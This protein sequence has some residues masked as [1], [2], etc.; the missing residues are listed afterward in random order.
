MEH[1]P[2]R[3]ER[4]A[5]DDP[6]RCQGVIP[7]R[8]QCQNR[9]MDD[10]KFC[11]AHGGNRAQAGRVKQEQRLYRLGKWQQRMQEFSDDS[12]IKDLRDEIGILKMML[13]QRLLACQSDVDL[14]LHSQSISQM[15]ANIERLVLSCQRLDTQLG[16]LLD[17]SQ[18]IAWMDK[19]VDIVSEHVT[20]PDAL[21]D[22]ATRLVETFQE[23]KRNAAVDS[24]PS[25]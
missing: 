13:E 18:A 6:R 19:I 3:F 24:R 1:D 25:G 15:V 8:G 7:T 4:V 14:M 10:S 11:P 22:I 9:A 2:S 21:N 16:N 12:R 20:D 5:E 23:V 17:P